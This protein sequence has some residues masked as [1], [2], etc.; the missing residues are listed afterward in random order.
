MRGDKLGSI[1]Q[2]VRPSHLDGLSFGWGSV[3]D[4]VEVLRGT[5]HCSELNVN[6][7]QTEAH[8]HISECGRWNGQDEEELWEESGGHLDVLG[9]KIVAVGAVVKHDLVEGG[10]AE[11]QHLA[12]VVAAVLVFAYDPLTDGELLHRSLA[13]LWRDRK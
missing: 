8:A 9:E 13:A 5:T 11:L 4:A 2:T 12:V 6:N 1:Y 7:S 3:S 10:R